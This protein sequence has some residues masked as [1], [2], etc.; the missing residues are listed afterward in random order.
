MLYEKN[1]SQ[2]SVTYLSLNNEL[3]KF[4]TKINGD[5][6]YFEAVEG[7]LLSIGQSEYEFKSV[8]MRKIVLNIQSGD[9]HYQVSF[10]Y[11][12]F[13]TITLLN[14]MLTIPDPL[15]G[16][17]IL[18]TISGDEKNNETFWKPFVQYNGDWLK[19][20]HKND[21]LKKLKIYGA[22]SKIERENAMAAY[23]DKAFEVLATKNVETHTPQA[24]EIDD[25]DD[26]DEVPF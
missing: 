20:K 5:K 25:A 13:F 12:A 11:G 10:G 19:Q 1:P 9:D 4:Q 18:V 8:K 14:F 6:K 22:E 17:N 21:D 7:K 23:L 3:G 26:D 16:G 24:E 2:K 15:F